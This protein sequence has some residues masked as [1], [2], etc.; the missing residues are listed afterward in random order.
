MMVSRDQRFGSGDGEKFVEV[1]FVCETSRQ[2]RRALATTSTNFYT[3]ALND[4]STQRRHHLLDCYMQQE[5]L[6]YLVG[7]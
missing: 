6:E 4:V 7:T 2:T 3:K 1:N 5:S